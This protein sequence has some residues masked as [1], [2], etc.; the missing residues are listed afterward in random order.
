VHLLAA[1]ARR[2]PVQHAGPLDERVD[3]AGPDR[4]VV[5]DEV[6]LGRAALRE[7]D[8]VGLVT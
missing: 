5:L 6:E 2:E 3:D 4:E 7:V 8:P 1:T